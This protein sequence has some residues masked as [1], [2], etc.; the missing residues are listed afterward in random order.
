MTPGGVSA[1]LTRAFIFDLY[2]LPMYVISLAY[3]T[4]MEAI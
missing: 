4:A 1:S 2:I 3:E